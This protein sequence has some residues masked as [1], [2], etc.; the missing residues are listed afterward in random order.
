MRL[1]KACK[2]RFHRLYSQ[3]GVRRTVSITITL[4][5]V[6]FLILLL[7]REGTNLRQFSNWRAYL[8]ACAI[9][10]LLYPLSLI[11]HASVWTSMI[12]KLG[13]SKNVWEDVKIYAY[14]S[15]VRRLPGAIWYLATRTMMYHDQGVSA[16]ATLAASGLEWLWMLSAGVLI[17]GLLSLRGL[18]PWL[19]ALT[20]IGLLWAASSWAPQLFSFLSRCQNLPR[21]IERGLGKLNGATMP[22]P[23]DVFPWLGAYMATYGIA[24]TILHVVIQTVEPTSSLVLS[25]ALR[26]WGLTSSASALVVSLVP[27]GL[28]VRELTITALLGPEIPLASSLFIATMMRVIFLA[29]DLLWGALMLSIAHLASRRLAPDDTGRETERNPQLSD[30]PKS[31]K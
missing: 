26:I 18:T 23:G 14:T 28:G 16:S 29:G 20:V 31:P 12:S 4:F 21:F 22:A 13:Q 9:G 1:I 3:P 24:G 10:L 2:E 15:I 5:S 17:Y 25:D 6:G 7:K 19:L 30:S 8:R 11:I 27:A